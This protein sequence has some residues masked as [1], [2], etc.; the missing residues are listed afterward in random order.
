MWGRQRPGISPPADRAARG[1]T[2]PIFGREQLREI[3]RLPPQ[4]GPHASG[5]PARSGDHNPA[6]SDTAHDAH[7]SLQTTTPAPALSQ[8]VARADTGN[9]A[10]NPGDS[11]EQTADRLTPRQVFGAIGLSIAIALVGI[12][13]FLLGLT[14]VFRQAE[15]VRLEVDPA[16]WDLGEVWAQSG[17]VWELPVRNTGIRPVAV[18]DV[19]T[20]GCLCTSV[21]PRQFE[22]APGA[23]KKLR[24]TLDLAAGDERRSVLPNEDLAIRIQLMIDDDNAV[25]PAWVLAGRIRRAF[26]VHPLYL[27]FGGFAGPVVGADGP[28]KH[29][30]LEPLERVAEVFAESTESLRTSV[31]RRGGR[32]RVFVQPMGNIPPGD[33]TYEV[34]IRVRLSSGE[35][36]PPYPVCVIGHCM[37]DIEAVPPSI[38]F[39]LVDAGRSAGTE[40]L[41]RSHRAAIS[42]VQ[43]MRGE[44]DCIIGHV[45]SRSP[46][47]LQIRVELKAEAPFVASCAC[48]Y[49]CKTASSG[50]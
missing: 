31:T 34:P 2:L 30:D 16:A 7:G 1:V 29:I 27:H 24:L 38:N 26:R 45:E 12:G 3:S 47:F 49:C 18:L 40:L 33:F 37:D 4:L 6:P 11:A 25:S 44:P 48:C 15:R 42:S 36:L 19:H 10:S 23:Q 17:L 50:N 20:S 9:R 21:T 43:E 46:D 22:V 13:G 35:L 14:H 8:P 28:V 5:G 32:W 41:V 39:G